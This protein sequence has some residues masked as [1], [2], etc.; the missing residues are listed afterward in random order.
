MLCRRIAIV[1]VVKMMYNKLQKSGVLILRFY[2]K[3]KSR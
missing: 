2:K 1:V 3:K